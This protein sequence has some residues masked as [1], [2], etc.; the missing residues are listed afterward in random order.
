MF[1]T[2]NLLF[3]ITTYKRSK[4]MNYFNSNSNSLLKRNKLGMKAKKALL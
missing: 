2:Q 4:G 3:V 1:F